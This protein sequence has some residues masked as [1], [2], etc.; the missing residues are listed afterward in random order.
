M[1]VIPE[2]KSTR[3]VAGTSHCTDGRPR[4]GKQTWPQRRAI[5]RAARSFISAL[6]NF[7]SQRS[8]S[9]SSGTVIS[10]TASLSGGFASYR[11]G[12]ESPQCIANRP[13][14]RIRKLLRCYTAAT[15]ASYPK[16]RRY[17]TLLVSSR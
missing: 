9:A 1:G 7:H 14:R 15:H 17:R 16:K 8:R 13:A 2:A 3:I 5:P 10:K 12:S 6:A 4:W 11:L